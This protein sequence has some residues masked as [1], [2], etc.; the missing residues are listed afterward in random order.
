MQ[1]GIQNRR[2]IADDIFK[3]IFLNV[4]DDMPIQIASK[5]VPMGPVDDMLPL[6][7]VKARCQIG[8]KPLPEPM[9]AQNH[10]ATLRL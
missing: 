2:H 7:Q 9:M 5:L 6:S 10:Y 8:A 3:C 1:W 4:N